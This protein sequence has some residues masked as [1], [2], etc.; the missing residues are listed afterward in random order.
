MQSLNWNSHAKTPSENYS[1]IATSHC[2]TPIVQSISKRMFWKG[3]GWI[4]AAFLSQNNLGIP[5]RAGTFTFLI[6]L[7]PQLLSGFMQTGTEMIAESRH[8]IYLT[9]TP[10]AIEE[11]LAGCMFCPTVFKYILKKC[12]QNMICF[13]KIMKRFIWSWRSPQSKRKD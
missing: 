12:D 3:P 1:S 4:A 11:M 9:G 5:S 13:E 7:S 2:W 10:G 6:S 8:P